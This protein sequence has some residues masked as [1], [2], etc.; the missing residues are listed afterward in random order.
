MVGRMGRAGG[1]G[2]KLGAEH[3]GM[4]LK[5]DFLHLLV[6]VRDRSDGVAPSGKAKGGALNLLETKKRG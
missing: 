2:Q 4:R 1:C 6:K 3:M 5:W